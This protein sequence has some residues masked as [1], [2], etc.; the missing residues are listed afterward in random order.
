[1]DGAI[2]FLSLSFF[3]D[4]TQTRLFSLRTTAGERRTLAAFLAG[5][6]AAFLATGACGYERAGR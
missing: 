1:M 6:L 3:K 4:P 5:F 2:F